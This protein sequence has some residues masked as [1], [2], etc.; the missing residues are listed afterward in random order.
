MEEVGEIDRGLAGVPVG[1]ILEVRYEQLQQEPRVT[2]SRMAKFLGLECKQKWLE[3][4]AS[5]PFANRRQ[6]S[7]RTPLEPRD[8]ELIRSVQGP[9]LQRFGYIG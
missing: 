3:A 4:A 7:S 9:L 6:S 1:Q 8:Q 2:L 5:V